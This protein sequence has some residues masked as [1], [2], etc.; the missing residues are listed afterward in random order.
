MKKSVDYCNV[1]LDVIKSEAK[2]KEERNQKCRHL[3]R[4]PSGGA[5]RIGQ[6]RAGG[7]R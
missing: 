4:L 2:K 3:F 1:S 5:Q 6:I 7:T